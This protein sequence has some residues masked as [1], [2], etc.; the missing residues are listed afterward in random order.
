M[1]AVER[2]A[3]QQDAHRKVILLTRKYNWYS[4]ELFAR[5]YLEGDQTFSP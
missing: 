5:F 3:Y 4:E 2:Y 1:A